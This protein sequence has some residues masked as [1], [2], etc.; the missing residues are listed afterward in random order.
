MLNLEGLRA[1]VEADETLKPY[2]EAAAKAISRRRC[3]RWGLVIAVVAAALLCVSKDE[4]SPCPRGCTVAERRLDE[5]MLDA[6]ARMPDDSGDM[7]TLAVEAI[8]TVRFEPGPDTPERTALYVHA[9]TIVG[10]CREVPGAAEW[11]EPALSH[12][13]RRVSQCAA[14]WYRKINPAFERDARLVRLVR[15]AQGK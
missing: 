10:S 7:R 11:A 3:A 12:P 8:K 4:T 1:R 6:I 2:A 15:A 5:R 14:I 9:L 13:A